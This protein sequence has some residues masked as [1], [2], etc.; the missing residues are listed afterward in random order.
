MAFEHPTPRVATFSLGCLFPVFQPP[1]A[2]PLPLFPTI[3]LT[4]IRDLLKGDPTFAHAQVAFIIRFCRRLLM[5][6]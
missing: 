6:G 2:P 1:P 3:L 5:G 4:F